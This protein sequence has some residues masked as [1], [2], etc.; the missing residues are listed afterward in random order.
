MRARAPLKILHKRHVFAVQGVLGDLHLSAVVLSR[1]KRRTW[2]AAC[3]HTEA[4]WLEEAWE[5]ADR[6]EE[7]A[8]SRIY[9]KGGGMVR[10]TVHKGRGCNSRSRG[11]EQGRTQCRTNRCAGCAGK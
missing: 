4:G 3:D 7:E 8:E 9:Y 1:E 2:F 11:R 10:V 5:V 6:G